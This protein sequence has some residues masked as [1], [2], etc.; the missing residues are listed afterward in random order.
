MSSSDLMLHFANPETFASLSLGSRLLAGLITTCLGM[1][2]T[3][4]ALILLQF[5]ISWMERFVN[6]GSAVTLPKPPAKVAAGPLAADREAASDNRRDSS[7]DGLDGHLAAV[8]TAVL[9]H[10][11]G[12]TSD[13]I[14]IRNIVRTTD[15]IPPWSRAG[16]V[17]Q[18]NSRL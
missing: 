5:I 14:V 6:R 10:H 4:C 11:L 17:E 3:F 16:L 12:T 7:D 9:A 13:N 8:I 18:I 2:I 1:G 15:P